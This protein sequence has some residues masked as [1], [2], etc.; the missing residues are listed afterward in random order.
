MHQNIIAQIDLNF[1]DEPNSINSRKILVGKNLDTK[2][3]MSGIIE[4]L[5]NTNFLDISHIS[6]YDFTWET[7][8]AIIHEWINECSTVHDDLTIENPRHHEYLNVGT[9][10]SDH[11]YSGYG[12]LQLV[13]ERR[14]L[15]NE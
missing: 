14:Y 13:Y 7:N 12:V 1:P 2:K 8:E 11:Q 6:L 4:F 5:T 9:F 3:I 15:E 10:Q